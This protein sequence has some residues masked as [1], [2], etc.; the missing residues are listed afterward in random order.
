M[1]SALRLFLFCAISLATIFYAHGKPWLHQLDIGTAN[2]P[3]RFGYHVSRTEAQD[4]DRY[5]ITIDPA[6]AAVLESA[7]LFWPGG[8]HETRNME[9]IKVDGKTQ[10]EFT[11]PPDFL[12]PSSFLRLHSGPIR[13]CGQENLENFEGYQLRLDNIPRNSS[14][15][16][17]FVP[18]VKM[19]EGAFEFSYT[20]GEPARISGPPPEFARQILAITMVSTTNASLSLPLRSENSVVEQ[21]VKFVLPKDQV[22]DFMLVASLTHKADYTGADAKQH[23]VGLGILAA[24]AEFAAKTAP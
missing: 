24:N 7:S 15:D 11:V 8:K 12:Q 23:Y 9:I 21:T 5:L 19:V 20:L 6:A 1:N 17:H 18:T 13:Y 22:A 16:F 4:K 2:H 14:R 10:I 3:S